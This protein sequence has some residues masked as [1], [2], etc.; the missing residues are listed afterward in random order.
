MLTQLKVLEFFSGLEFFR[1]CARSQGS[2]AKKQPFL[3]SMCDKA[4]A[5]GHSQRARWKVAKRCKCSEG[6]GCPGRWGAVDILDNTKLVSGFVL[7][8]EPGGI[9]L[10]LD[11]TD[12]IQPRGERGG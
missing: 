8:L 9:L 12:I 4:T 5:N 7:F 6:G 3:A 1:T 11:T 2:A 10:S